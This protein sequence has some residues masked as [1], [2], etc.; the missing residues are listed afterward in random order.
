LAPSYSTPASAGDMLARSSAQPIVYAFSSVNPGSSASNAILQQHDANAYGPTTI[1]LSVIISAPPASTASASGATSTAT[2]TGGIPTAVPATVASPKM[3]YDTIILAHAIIGSIAWM[4]ISPL[5]IL[6][7][8]YGRGWRHWVK[9]HQLLQT[10]LT[11]L[12]TLIAV[13]LGCVAV[14]QHNT[15]HWSSSHQKIGLVILIVLVV[16]G[17]LGAYNHHKY[18]PDRTKKPWR[19]IVHIILGIGLTAL[20]FAQVRL[21][22]PLYFKRYGDIT[23]K[24]VLGIYGL[25]V[26]VI[27]LALLFGI[28]RAFWSRS[29]SGESLRS[30]RTSRMNGEP[31]ESDKPIMSS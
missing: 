30:E 11:T 31:T 15:K 17:V 1:D 16:Q 23:P 12:L 21:G 24:G 5:A 2:A 14:K 20:G 28:F 13:I 22:M 27:S 19:N 8:T 10:V 9:A 3:S 25:L 29:K 18:S 26:G 7:A 6:V 4:I